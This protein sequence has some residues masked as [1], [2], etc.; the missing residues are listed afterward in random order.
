MWDKAQQDDIFPEPTK[1]Q[2]SPVEEEFDDDPYSQYYSNIDRMSEEDDSL[3]H[4]GKTPNPVFP[5]SVGKDQNFPMAP[6][7]NTKALQEVMDLKKELYDVEC[8]L[9][10][11]DAGGKKWSLKPVKT[12]DKQLWN[13]I[14]SIRKRIDVLSDS[15]GLE[16]EPD[17]SMWTVK[18][19]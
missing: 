13:K 2:P 3:L 6:W 16:D 7:T 8:K 17:A 15:L 14:E 5:D 11:Q 19:K 10:T 4:E 18:V 9:N 12:N 1:A